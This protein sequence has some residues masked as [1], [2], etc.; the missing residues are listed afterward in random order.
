MKICFWVAIVGAAALL[1]IGC[2][3]GGEDTETSVD[4]DSGTEK[5]V[6]EQ[7]RKPETREL[8]VT[9]NGYEGPEN[10]G[11]LMAEQRG[12]FRDEGLKVFAT[13]P[14]SPD[15]P[16]E[17]LSGGLVDI[18]VTNQPQLVMDAEGGAAA[19]AVGSVIPRPTAA[20][21]WL[22]KSKIRG[23]EDLKGKTIAIPGLDFQDGFLEA[24][25]AQGGLTLNDV[26]V[27]SA[28]YELVSA[29][30]S[31]R[32][33]A[34]FG[35]TWNLEGAALE[36]R[37]LKPVI[38]PVETLGVPGYDELVVIAN[39]DSLAENPDSIRRFMSALGRGTAAAIKNPEGALKAIEKAEE[40][41]PELNRKELKAQIEATLPLLSRTGRMDSGQA[42]GLIDWMQ[43]EGMI[44]GKPSASELLTNDYLAPQP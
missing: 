11:I 21:I 39:A 36:A 9:F 14:L 5:T 18:V 34:I 43:E 4:R 1:L 6:D 20:M 3:G 12:Y 33:D 29:L 35:G 7:P 31:G 28:N 15:A 16:L 8:N 30:V 2:G 19:T 27:E 38:T 37:G 42:E 26:E 13:Q 24:V 17:F 32:A 44:Q 25:L 10:V 40:E 22:P 23:I 41:N